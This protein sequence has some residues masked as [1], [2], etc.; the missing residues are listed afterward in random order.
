M[1]T[2]YCEFFLNTCH[3]YDVNLFIFGQLC[4]RGDIHSSCIRRPKYLILR[5]TSYINFGARELVWNIRT[6]CASTPS[7]SN[8]PL[9]ILLDCVALFV[10]NITDLS[11]T[12]LTVSF[13]RVMG[14]VMAHNT[15]FVYARMLA[16]QSHQGSTCFPPRGHHRSRRAMYHSC[17]SGS[18]SPPSSIVVSP[19]V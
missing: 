17:L 14:F 19:L 2:F 5:F 6:T 15:Y 8:L 4:D 16:D 10:T 3:T 11:W 12:H 18:G 7:L 9:Y 1:D 13:T